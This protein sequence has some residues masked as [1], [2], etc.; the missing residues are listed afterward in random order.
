M[1][2][3]SGVFVSAR[4]ILEALMK[5]PLRETLASVAPQIVKLE[6]KINVVHP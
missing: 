1:I 2:L 6:K 5:Y 4:H 3:Q